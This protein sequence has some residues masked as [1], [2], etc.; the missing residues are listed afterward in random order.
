MRRRYLVV[1]IVLALAGF[2]LGA[3]KGPG[4]SIT[5]PSPTPSAT[6]TPSPAPPPPGGWVGYVGCSNTGNTAAGYHLDGGHRLWGTTKTSFFDGGTVHR[7]AV[8]IDPSSSYAVFWDRLSSLLQAYP[9]AVIWWELCQRQ[10]EAGFDLDADARAVEAELERRA[11]G[12]PIDVSGL[13]GYVAPHVCQITGPDGPANTWA[14]AEA[15]ELPLGPYPGDLRS[16]YQTPS[17]PPGDQ[18]VEDGC[19][20]NAAGERLLGQALLA[21]F[22]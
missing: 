8:G 2:T 17:D 1:G 21:Y 15:L 9:P 13:N 22:G 20:P 14:A 16:I 10:D 19:H 18:T 7:W 6:K 3:T 11:P 12:I 5:K 4:P